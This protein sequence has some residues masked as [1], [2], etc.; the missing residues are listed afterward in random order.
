MIHY[1]VDSNSIWVEPTKNKNKGKL[2][3]VRSHALIRMKACGIT[4]RH[5]VLDNEIST[6]YKNA[7]TTSGM[8]YQLVPPNDHRRNIAEKAIQTWK[9]YFVATL[10][11]TADNFPLHLWCQLIS[12]MERQLNLLRQS[13]SNP[14]IS[15]YAHLYSHHDYNSH[16]FVP[17][18]MEA[19]VH[20]KPHRKKSFAQHCTKGFVLGTST[21]HYRCW[22]V[23]TPVSRSTRISATVFFKHKYITNPTITPAGAIIAATANLAHVLMSNNVEAHLNSS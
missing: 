10:S 21:E 7:I 20:D 16:P 11:G 9:D 1:H 3:L 2:I 6:A 12:Q 13:R 22:I 4:P 19:L 8:T 5:Q 15:A 23:W 14:R 17:I 18:G